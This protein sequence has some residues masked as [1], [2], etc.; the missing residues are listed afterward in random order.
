[1]SIEQWAKRLKLNPNSPTTQQLYDNRHL[2]V[3]EYTAKFRKGGINEVLPNEAKTMSVEEA[4][5]KQ[6]VGGRNMRKLL[7]SGRDKFKK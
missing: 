4:L 1:M 5:E 2:T 3:A 7:A 6:S